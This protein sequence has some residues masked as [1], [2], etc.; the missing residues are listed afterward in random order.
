MCF[1]SRLEEW[2]ESKDPRARGCGCAALTVIGLLA[3]VCLMFPCMGDYIG[4]REGAAQDARLKN[5][6]MAVAFGAL[7]FCGIFGNWLVSRR[8]P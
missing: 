8:R 7:I 4:P 1:F 5:T 6:L 2:K 3:F